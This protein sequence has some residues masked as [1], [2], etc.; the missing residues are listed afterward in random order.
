MFFEKEEVHS[1]AYVGS[2][3]IQLDVFHLRI[4]SNLD[5]GHETSKLCRYGDY[6]YM[7]RFEWKYQHDRDFYELVV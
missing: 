2:V 7:R 6:Y 3:S 4:I 1:D 5:R